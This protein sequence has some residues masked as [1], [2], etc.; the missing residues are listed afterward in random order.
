MKNAVLIRSLRLE[1]KRLVEAAKQLANPADSR[2][3]TD[4]EKTQL[5]S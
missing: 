3:L 5:D 1:K 4:D 2:A